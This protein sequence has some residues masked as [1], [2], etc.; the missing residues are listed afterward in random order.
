MAI[1][2][3]KLSETELRLKSMV[4]EYAKDVIKGRMKFYPENDKDEDYYEAYDVK[5]IVNQS[6]K[7]EDV[8]VML[9][10]GGPTVYL[11]TH[12]EEVQGFWGGEKY[13]KWIY[14]YDYIIEHFDEYYS[15]LK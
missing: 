8:I 5:Y 2:K 12:A 6:G 15:C 11:D 7:L 14:D 10:G 9:A 13:T 3:E 1:G 4:D